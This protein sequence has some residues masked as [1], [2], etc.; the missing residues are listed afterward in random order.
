MVTLTAF[1]SSGSRTGAAAPE[2]AAADCLD[3][4]ET[5]SRE[6]REQLLFSRLPH[7]LR[8]ARVARGWAWLTN[9]TLPG[10]V[11]SRAALARLPVLRRGDLAAM[12]AGRPP[13]GGLVPEPAGSFKRIFANPAGARLV[14][15][16]EATGQDS[17][18]AG[19]ALHAAG[20]RKGDVVINALPYHLASTG[21]IV[22]SACRTLGSPVVPAG[23]AEFSDELDLRIEII[24]HLMPTAIAGTGELVL[25]LLDR[26]AA[27][28]RDV[29]SLG[30]A[31]LTEGGTDPATRALIQR[32]GVDV[33][34]TMLVP[35][36]GIV[37]FEDG[38]GGFVLNEDLIAEIVHPGTGEPV[39]PGEAGELV[40]TSF[41]PHHPFIRLGTGQLTAE[42]L[43]DR[44]A[45]RTNLRLAGWLGSAEQQAR[46]GEVSISAAQIAQLRRSHPELKRVR[47]SLRQ[48]GAGEEAVLC[49]L[50]EE[51]TGGEGDAQRAALA[52]RVAASLA[53]IARIAGRVELV[54]EGLPNDGRLVSD[55]RV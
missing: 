28:G 34:D 46:F 49:G 35:E 53:R 38:A 32:R 42:C 10:D 26:A 37:A 45:A 9:G 2:L 25:R 48:T 27:T 1:R 54:H 7:L 8:S 18:L 17:W 23:P 52:A 15:A 30:I 44:P 5:A 21:F 12:Q 50:I 20:V 22:D 14:L 36:I 41:D 29:S 24:E 19:R 4:R 51:E 13:F 3:D 40:I 39:A 11:A 55:E 33:F 16:P 31:F 47:L 43:P 6:E